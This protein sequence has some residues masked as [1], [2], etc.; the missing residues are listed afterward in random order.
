M[1][2]GGMNFTKRYYTMPHHHDDPT[3]PILMANG[4]LDPYAKQPAVRYTYLLV[5]RRW[6]ESVR[7][8]LDMSNHYLTII[9]IY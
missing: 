5:E 7:Q 8:A 2:A 9:I 4:E 6:H 3:K 1:F